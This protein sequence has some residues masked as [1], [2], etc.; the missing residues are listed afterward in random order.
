MSF[1]WSYAQFLLISAKYMLKNYY[2]T[3]LNSMNMNEI[4]SVIVTL[5]YV[6]HSAFLVISSLSGMP[7]APFS[8]QSDS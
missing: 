4:Y 2:G 5:E 3:W 6:S 8:L 1:I 7:F